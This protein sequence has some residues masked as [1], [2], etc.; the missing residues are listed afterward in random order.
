MA[1]APFSHAAGPPALLAPDF[2]RM[3]H[4]LKQIHNWVLWVPYWIGSKWTKRPIQPS[5]FA[6]STTNPKH[7]SR[8]EDV[9]AAYELAASR[10]YIEFHEK[11]SAPQTVTVGGVGFVFDGQPD[12]NGLVL[13]GVDFDKVISPSSEIAS[14]AAERVRRLGSYCEVS[15]SGRGLHQILKARPLRAGIAHGGTEIYTRGRFFTMT[16]RTGPT[17]RPIM[18]APDALEALID[19]LRAHSAKEMEPADLPP[20]TPLT[21]VSELAAG[22]ETGHWYEELSQSEK[23]ALVDYAL[24]MIA[25]NTH[26]LELESNGGNNF[27]YYKLSTAV[28]RSGAP[29]AEEI[30]VKHASGAKDADSEDALRQHFSRCAQRRQGAPEITIGTLLLQAEQNGADFSSWKGTNNLTQ[31]TPAGNIEHLEFSSSPLFFTD[32]FAEFVGPAFPVSVLPPT[33]SGFVSAQH[34]AMGADP[35]A[36][37]MAALTTVAGSLHAETHVRMG[38]TWGEK[39]ILWVA[40]VGQPSTMKSP[41]IDKATKPLRRIDHRR[42]ALWRQQ[43]AQWQQQNKG[44]KNPAP[45]PP[46]PARSIINDATPEKTAEILS[47]DPRGA[48]MVHDELAGWLGGFE[49]YSSGASSRAFQLTCWNGGPYIKDR[50]GQGARDPYAE[51][52]VENLALSLLGGIQPDRLSAMRDLTSDGLLQRLLPVLMRPA[53]R[54]DQNFPAAVSEDAYERLIQLVHCASPRRYQFDNDGLRVRDRMLDYL[55]TLE[56]LEGLSPP[57]VAAIGKLKG[58]FGRI[59]LVLHVAHE[60]DAMLRGTGLGTGA[61]IDRLAAESTE[62]I[63]RE[64]LL[65]HMFGLYDVVVNGGRERDTIR[66]IASFILASDKDRL[67]LSD[68]TSGVRSLRGDKQQSISDWAG[69]FCAMGWLRPENENAAQPKAWLVIQGLREHFAERRE[70]ARAARAAAH[71]ILKAGGSRRAA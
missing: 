52:R 5:G 1:E 9:R 8:F 71:E 13:A 3:P 41:I 55:Y 49:R 66:A 15:V 65:P 45:R 50:V 47:R 70:Q 2:D 14:L 63:V 19:E 53:E 57:L 43:D 62:K 26:L 59:A 29:H 28:A 64:F 58:Y 67:R 54:G 4:E 69:R 37:A 36:L 27:E 16:G 61:P 23:D 30:F 20:L 25:K 22:I 18:A 32:P 39:P 38:D 34:C 31:V 68:F 24:G 44:T 17:T 48:L 51:L 21:G 42:D 60:Y 35:A 46:K 40:L 11:S 12:G 7:W 56:Q 33:L 10:G 6:A